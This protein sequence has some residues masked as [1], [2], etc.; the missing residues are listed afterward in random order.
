MQEDPDPHLSSLPNNLFK[1]KAH[2]PRGRGPAHF[3]PGSGPS[4]PLGPLRP[5]KSQLRIGRWTRIPHLVGSQHLPTYAR[6]THSMP[7]RLIIYPPRD[8]SLPFMSMPA[9]DSRMSARRYIS[10]RTRLSPIE[11]EGGKTMQHVV[12]VEGERCGPA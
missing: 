2:A 4:R 8:P 1:F 7:I 12:L 9:L 3:V 5:L 6:T 11:D 10:I